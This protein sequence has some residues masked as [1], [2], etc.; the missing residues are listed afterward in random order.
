MAYYFILALHLTVCLILIAV[1]LL[2]SG[3]GA[4]LAGAFGGGGSQTAFGARGAGTFL[5]KLTTACAILFMI[6]SLSL[7]VLYNQ[8]T[9]GSVMEGVPVSQKPAA[10][11]Q[12]QQPKPAEPASAPSQQ[13]TVPSAAPSQAAP[14]A[15]RS[16]PE[17]K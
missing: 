15:G 17:K 2:Q 12:S 13:P 3:K 11:P 10:V 9:S 1:V 14:P 16:A 6:T 5:S 4:D 8:K 7:A